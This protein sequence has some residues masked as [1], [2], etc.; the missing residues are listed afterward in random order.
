LVNKLEI[1]FGSP[2][3]VIVEQEKP[4]EIFACLTLDLGPYSVTAG[5]DVML[6]MP[7]RFGVGLIVSYVDAGGNPATVDGD[8]SWTSSDEN[9]A[10]VQVDAGD[11]KKC[12]VVAGDTLGQAQVTA[13]ADADLGE[14]MRELTCFLDVKVIAGEAVAGTISPDGTPE[15]VAG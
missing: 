4:P 14:G 7:V 8:V 3:R 10:T 13:T 11:S 15:P 12:R 1:S 6:T 2:L 9:I 5:D